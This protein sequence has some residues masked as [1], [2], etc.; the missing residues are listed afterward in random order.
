MT[1]LI[2]EFVEDSLKDAR[3]E[4]FK[5]F[6]RGIQEHQRCIKFLRDR[7]KALKERYR[8]KKD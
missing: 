6:D 8:I 7:K 2:H 3:T 1:T 4:V 5:S